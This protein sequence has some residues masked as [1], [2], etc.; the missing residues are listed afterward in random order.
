MLHFSVQVFYDNY[1]RKVVK[2]KNS[3]I[4]TN[5]EFGLEFQETAYQFQLSVYQNLNFGAFRE[6]S[7]SQIDVVHEEQ[8][9]WRRLV[10]ENP[11]NRF[12]IAPVEQSAGVQTAKKNW[13][14]I[15]CRP[16]TLETGGVPD[17]TGSQ[18]FR[19]HLQSVR[20]TASESG[21]VHGEDPVLG[22]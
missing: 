2:L 13:S 8:I 1:K 17:R 15:V 22:E 14:S 4:Q 20:P 5:D 18:R 11:A 9:A 12:N 21:M 16:G 7:S 19:F 10:H 6:D 3:N